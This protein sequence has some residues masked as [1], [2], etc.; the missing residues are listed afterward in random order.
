M[1]KG[2][3]AFD[4]F[5]SSPV[6][7]S[8]L[9]A[10]FEN[11]EDSH[12]FDSLKDIPKSPTSVVLPQATEIQVDSENYGIIRI[13]EIMGNRYKV[14]GKGGTGMFS[15]VLK[16]WDLENNNREVAIKMLRKN[17]MMKRVGVKEAEYL[18]EI[19]D[20]DPEGRFCC[21]KLLNHFLDRDFLCLVFD[22]ME[23]N[24]TELVKKFGKGAGL[25]VKVVC[26]YTKQLLFAL[27]HLKRHELI[28]ADIKPDN[29]LV[30]NARNRVF[31]GDFGS[32]IK[33]KEVQVTPHLVSGY[34]RAPEVNLGIPTYSYDL[35][36]WSIACC[37]F[38][39]ATGKLLFKGV[40]NNDMLRLHMELKGTISR[41]LLKRAAFRGEYFDDN[42]N[43]LMQKT[44]Q[45]TGHVSLQVVAAVPATRDLKAELLQ[46]VA[47]E[48]KK[49]Y[50]ELYDL[51]MQMLSL[52]PSK[53]IKIEQA[54]KHPFIAEKSS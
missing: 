29:V 7:S 34:Y 26:S 38:E 4:M 20:T 10:N 27:Y 11:P 52:D 5:S 44:N 32:M 33:A 23:S 45:T 13:G 1:K 36:M 28:H 46:N 16:A 15:K 47:P 12:T 54:L 50:L 49:K 2:S 48:D 35:D 41:K 18:K 17:D 19:S 25:P 6:T 43:F 40:S 8:V 39:M 14:F 3:S 31:L 37:I 51:L 53:R 22:L 30:N 21:I 42:F 24:L 9:S